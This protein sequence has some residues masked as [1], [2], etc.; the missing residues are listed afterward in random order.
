MAENTEAVLARVAENL[1]S[2]GERQGEHT[3]SIEQLKDMVFKQIELQTK[4]QETSDAVERA[5]KKLEDHETRIE[6]LDKARASLSGGMVAVSIMIGGFIAVMGWALHGQLEIAQ[7]LPVWKFSVDQRLH[8]LEIFGRTA[9][10]QGR[11]ER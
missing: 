9:E 1:R 10:D 7:T 5:F 6:S 4:Q 11:A 2:V 8:A 3:K